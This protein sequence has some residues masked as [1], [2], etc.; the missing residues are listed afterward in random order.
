M[1]KKDPERDNCS[2]PE[3]A[4]DEEEYDPTTDSSTLPAVAITTNPPNTTPGIV[5]EG[6][7]TVAATTTADYA[8]GGVVEDTTFND[9]ASAVATT[10]KEVRVAD[11]PPATITTADRASKRQQK[12]G[13]ASTTKNNKKKGGTPRAAPEKRNGGVKRVLDDHQDTLVPTTTDILPTT[14]DILPDFATI[15]TAD[16]TSKRQKAVA[17]MKKEADARRPVEKSNGGKRVLVEEEPTVDVIGGLT[18]EDPATI[19][20]LPPNFDHDDHSSSFFVSDVIYE[21]SA[22]TFSDL[23]ARDIH[24]RFKPRNDNEDPFKQHE[25][26]RIYCPE[27]EERIVNEPVKKSDLNM[28][29]FCKGGMDKIKRHSRNGCNLAVANFFHQHKEAHTAKTYAAYCLARGSKTK[30]NILTLDK[31]VSRSAVVDIVKRRFNTAILIIN[32]RKFRGRKSRQKMQ[33][34]DVLKEA[35]DIQKGEAEDIREEEELAVTEKDYSNGKATRADVKK[36]AAIF[37]KRIRND[38]V[39]VLNDPNWQKS[40]LVNM[41]RAQFINRLNRLMW[42][43][44]D[45]WEN[46]FILGDNVYFDDSELTFG[47]V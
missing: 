21:P 27:C 47:L 46:N 1:N 37:L 9:D 44:D 16:R 34:D 20:D 43:K 23:L 42:S 3:E 19:G 7:P 18:E 14:T 38:F 5:S 24:W 45:L 15:T 28:L 13:V 8:A 6:G 41:T 12:P 22:R 30:P 29:E 2:A 17:T 31:V 11:I 33:K 40:N 32:A 36:K 26:G 39:N 4:Y 35:E 25:D 10:T